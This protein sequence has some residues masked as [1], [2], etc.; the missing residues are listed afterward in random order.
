MDQ[1]D[2]A[3][4]IAQLRNDIAL[5]AAQQRPAAQLQELDESGQVICI[6]CGDQIVLAR[7]LAVPNAV[8]CVE[9]EGYQAAANGGRHGRV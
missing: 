9:C 8:R 5:K 7:L 1:A 3:N 6:D 2:N 4:D